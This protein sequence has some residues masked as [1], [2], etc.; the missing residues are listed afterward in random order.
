MT[1]MTDRP[2]SIYGIPAAEVRSK[3]EPGDVIACDLSLR[4]NAQASTRRKAELVSLDLHRHAPYG[5]AAAAAPVPVP[6]P[7][8]NLNQRHVGFLVKID[9]PNGPRLVVTKKV[10]GLWDAVDAEMAEREQRTAELRD[11]DKVRR[12]AAEVLGAQIVAALEARGEQRIYTGQSVFSFN[13]P[14]TLLARLL[15]V[16]V[17]EVLA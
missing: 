2:L 7:N 12:E 10:Y 6:V 17:P 4:R 1:T 14:V 13:V 8:G 5:Y 16:E 9:T 3:F 11:R 15:D